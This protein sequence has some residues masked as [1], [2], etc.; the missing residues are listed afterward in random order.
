MNNVSAWEVTFMSLLQWALSVDLKV[1]FVKKEE[2]KPALKARFCY[3]CGIV[4]IAKY[5]PPSFSKL[6]SVK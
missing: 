2:G 6:G 4:Y 5:F 1:G 3:L